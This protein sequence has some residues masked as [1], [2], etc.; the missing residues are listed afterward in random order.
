MLICPQDC[1]FCDLPDCRTA[2]CERTGELPLAECVECGAVFVQSA[3]GRTV[4]FALCVDCVPSG[5]SA[6]A[7]SKE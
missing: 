3:F 7:E 1:H 5:R 2:G 6:V 4:R